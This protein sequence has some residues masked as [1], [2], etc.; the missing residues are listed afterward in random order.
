MRLA[1]SITALLLLTSAAHAQD[2]QIE[3]GR[4]VMA[5]TAAPD[6]PSCAACHQQDGAGEPDAGIPGLAGLTA[7]Y[8]AEQLDF[9]AA[10]KRQSATMGDFAKALTPAQRD[11]VAAYL[12]SLPAITPQAS[13]P[14]AP[15]L[16]KRGEELFLDGDYRTGTVACALCHGRTGLGVGA[17]SPRLAGQS[18]LYTEQQLT[19]WASGDIRDPKGAFMKAVASHLSPSDIRAVSAYAAAMKIGGKP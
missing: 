6:Q 10:G 12:A 4:A 1:P 8:I 19:L 11:A 16:L 7:S 2:A 18:S 14:A 13:A 9:Y 5:R 3:A 15:D 17:F